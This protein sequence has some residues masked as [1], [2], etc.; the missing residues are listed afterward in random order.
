MHQGVGGDLPKPAARQ[1]LGAVE[2]EQA[3]EGSRANRHQERA[4]DH[5]DD[6]DDH[7]QRRDVNR[8]TTHPGHRLIVV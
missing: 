8:I 5:A 3:E 2:G 1:D 4:D 7:E 6:V